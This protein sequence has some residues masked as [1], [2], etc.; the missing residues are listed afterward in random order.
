MEA[1]RRIQDA[2]ADADADAVDDVRDMWMGDA[3]GGEIGRRAE[4]VDA[5]D[6]RRLILAGG[7]DAYAA[8]YVGLEGVGSEA[9]TTAERHRRVLPPRASPT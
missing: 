5:V 7:R 8:R 9:D 4:A 3:A 6:G 1:L 2:D